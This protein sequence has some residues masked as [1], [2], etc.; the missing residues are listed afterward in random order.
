MKI[1]IASLALALSTTALAE[2]S[3]VIGVEQAD[4]LPHYSGDTAKATIAASHAS[5]SIVSRR[6]PGYT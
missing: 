3:Y 6:R 4:F 1:L 5:C 2:Q